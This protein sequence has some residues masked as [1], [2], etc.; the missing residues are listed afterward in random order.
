[1]TTAAADP[2]NPAPAGNEGAP[3]GDPKGGDPAAPSS[4][5][6]SGAPTGSLANQGHGDQGQGDGKSLANQAS[7]QG[8]G[9]E[10]EGQ[11]EGDGKEGDGKEGG[12]PESYEAFK[13]P[14]GMSLNDE[15]LGEFSTTAKELGMSQEAAQRMVDF[16][17]KLVEQTQAAMVEQAT[18]QS[19]D[20]RKA[21]SEDAEIGGAKLQSEVIPAVALALDTF[22]NQELRAMLDSTQVGN[23]PEVV[24][25]LYKLGSQLKEGDFVNGDT[26]KQQDSSL[27]QKL[28][29][30]PS[31]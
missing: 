22:G 27:E 15:V 4:G 19:A 20:W 3:G 16:G 13:V 24:R 10:G 2:N 11:G 14:D 26:N 31:K 21:T 25:F 18:Q 6:P 23:H 8:D 1:M 12:A 9:K 7:G 29:G 5:E 30:A 28:Y 17:A